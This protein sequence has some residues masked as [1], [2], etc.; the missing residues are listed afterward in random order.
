M[1]TFNDYR[2]WADEERWGIINGEAYAMTPA[3]ISI[4]QRH[5]PENVRNI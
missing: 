3:P 5:G 1:L 4:I 2:S